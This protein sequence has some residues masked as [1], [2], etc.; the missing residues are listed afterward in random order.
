MRG[1]R[2]S[3]LVHLLS[4]PLTAGWAWPARQDLE[5]KGSGRGGTK[6]PPDI[7][8]VIRCGDEAPAGRAGL[9]R[10]AGQSGW[11][12]RDWPDGGE[13]GGGLDG[14][15]SSVVTRVGNMRATR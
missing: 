10:L 2:P 5:A 7:E 15:E 6:G 1:Q 11:F 8:K 3:R 13:A 4:K 14:L 9:G 12:V